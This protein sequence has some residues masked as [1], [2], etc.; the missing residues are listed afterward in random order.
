MQIAFY[1]DFAF[2]S[3]ASSWNNAR[4]TPRL[5]AWISIDRNCNN[6]VRNLCT[7]EKQQLQSQMY[8]RHLIEEPMHRCKANRKQNRVAA[9]RHHN[10]WCSPYWY[11]NISNQFQGS[12]VGTNQHNRYYCVA[13][14]NRN[15]IEKNRSH[16][17]LHY[18]TFGFLTWLKYKLQRPHTKLRRWVQMNH[19]KMKHRHWQLCGIK[20]DIQ[21]RLEWIF[22][23]VNDAGRTWR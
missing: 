19:H 21:C 4:S 2:Q 12:T 20:D 15:E 18:I 1:T 13:D 22:G 23:L 6:I 10:N 11:L 8:K 17:T 7:F 9:T 14:S 5:Q 3:A 16:I